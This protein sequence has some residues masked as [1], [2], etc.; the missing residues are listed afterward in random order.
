MIPG[1]VCVCSA[2]IIHVLVVL[3]LHAMAIRIFIVPIGCNSTD[4]RAH[5]EALIVET[6]R[7]RIIV[8]DDDTLKH[9]HPVAHTAFAPWCR[10]DKDAMT[11]FLFEQKFRTIFIKSI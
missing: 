9:R 3:L 1:V 11:T 6:L 5:Y 8:N 7:R 4:N 10:H 2:H